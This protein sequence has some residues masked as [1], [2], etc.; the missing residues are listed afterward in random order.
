MRAQT[1][2][3]FSTRQSIPA[4]LHHRA[5][6]RRNA[7]STYK[8]PMHDLFF[9]SQP[10]FMCVRRLSRQSSAAVAFRS[11]LPFL[12]VELP[13]GPRPVAFH[14][15]RAGLELLVG[16]GDA[17]HVTGGREAGGHVHEVV[18]EHRPGKGTGQDA[19]GQL[20]AAGA[21]NGNRK[22]YRLTPWSKRNTLSGQAILQN[23]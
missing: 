14:G 5:T 13:R 21:A 9:R 4:C 22:N 23:G 7:A 10:S 6:R 15:A 11:G 2:E 17:R 16:G 20:P 19:F 18:E 1:R 3:A 12:S 8:V